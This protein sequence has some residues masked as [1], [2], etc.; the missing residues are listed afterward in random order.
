MFSEKLTKYEE[1]WHGVDKFKEDIMLNYDA[2][3]NEMSLEPFNN[4][5]KKYKDAV[6]QT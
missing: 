3:V 6:R 4:I 2:I 1:A 5:M